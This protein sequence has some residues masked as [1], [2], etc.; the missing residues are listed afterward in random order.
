M[1][2]QYTKTTITIMYIHGLANDKIVEEVRSRLGRI[3]LDG[4]LESCYIEEM[5]EDSKWTP[6]PTVFNSERPDVI[7]AGL[8]EG[9]I[10][11]LVD[12]T[13]FSGT[14][15]VC[16]ILSSGGGSLP[17]S[18]YQHFNPFHSHHCL[19]YCSQ[20]SFALYR[21]HDI[22]SGDA[23]NQAAYDLAAQREGVPFPAFIEALMMEITFE[24]RREAGIRMP[25]A[26]GQAISIVGSLVIGQAAVG[27]GI[28][29]A[30][31][32]IVVAITA[33]S[34]FVLPSYNISITI[35]MLRFI[36]MGL[37]ASF[38]LYS[39]DRYLNFAFAYVQLAVLWRSLYES[40]CSVHSQ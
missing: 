28:V 13:P 4:I 8:L 22:S 29:S 34:S 7:A 31:M 40:V 1:A 17:T 37:A 9:R 23:S 12:G 10:T 39:I 3:R 21:H 15:I 30:A 35:R 33:I 26:V 14:R 11:L 18:G 16:P 19:I 5:I 38:G 2:G 24:T 32:V 20:C 27:A 6:F 25:K 36:L